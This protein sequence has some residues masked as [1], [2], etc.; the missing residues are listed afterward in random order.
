MLS[1][2]ALEVA[3]LHAPMTSSSGSLSVSSPVAER[4]E[5]REAILRVLERHRVRYVLIGGAAAQTRGWRG[6][7]LDVDITPDRDPAN[8][9]R[10]AEALTELDARFRVERH[11]DGFAPPGGIDART[12]R[13]QISVALL[14]RHGPLDVALIPDG[15]DGYDDLARNAS[16][17][18]VARTRVVALVASAEDII[19]SKTIANRTKDRDVLPQIAA[20]LRA[21][22]R[23]PGP[24]SRALNISRPQRR[25][26]AAH[27]VSA[28][29]AA[30]SANARR[31]GR[32]IGSGTC[33]DVLRPSVG[34]RVR[35]RWCKHR[36]GR[37]AILT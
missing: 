19:R 20:R 9:A 31:G 23:A 36:R 8:L 2:V 28:R 15:T 17:A 13:G 4:D 24:W 1:Y 18:T 33:V 6:V 11:P 25:T 7:T 37:R 5:D 14:T 16:R 32:S 35:V 26:A 3:A 22:N 27:G 34:A 21:C 10:L 30:S 29:P 12:F